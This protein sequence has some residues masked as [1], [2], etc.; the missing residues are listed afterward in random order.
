MAP[1]IIERN[2]QSDQ[3]SPWKVCTDAPSPRTPERVIH[4]PRRTMTKDTA[5]IMTAHFLKPSRRL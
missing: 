1:T 2:S 4:V 5:D 3:G